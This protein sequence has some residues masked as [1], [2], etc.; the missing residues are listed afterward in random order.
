MLIAK[1]NDCPKCGGGHI[2]ECYAVYDNGS[3]CFSC[4]YY[5]LTNGPK[6]NFKY[7]NSLINLPK[8][9]TSNINNMS[10]HI[11][12]WLY[13]N[14]IYKNLIHKYG[15]MYV[16]YDKFLLKSGSEYSGES[17]IFPVF[18]DHE[19]IYYQRRFFPHKQILTVGKCDKVFIAEKDRGDTIVIVE[20]FISAIRIGEICSSMC[21]FGTSLK[22]INLDYIMNNFLNVIVWLDGDTPGQNN[23]V[24]IIDIIQKRI[25]KYNIMQPFKKTKLNIFNT[26]TKKDPK[27]L[28]NL[29]ISNNIGEILNE[30]T[31]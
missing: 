23:A 5:S 1:S 28:T 29:E 26:S 8:H 17:L 22:K 14:H 6:Y 7:N 27:N 4:G 18:N 3:Y 19:L 21:L 15:I 10:P 25:K 2:N 31:Y 20:D 24:K 13:N 16:E 30:N 11:A 9:T 12:Q